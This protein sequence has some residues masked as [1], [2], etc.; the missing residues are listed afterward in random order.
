[1]Y[2]KLIFSKKTAFGNRRWLKLQ[3]KIL[4]E[5]D[6]VNVINHIESGKKKA[7][8]CREFG[9]GNSTIQ[10][11]RKTGTQSLVFLKE[12]DHQLNYYGSQNGATWTKR[13]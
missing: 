8:M 13:Y 2:G 11:R 4:S 3:R 9:L 5:E 6:E 12:M 10:T 1:M 7:D